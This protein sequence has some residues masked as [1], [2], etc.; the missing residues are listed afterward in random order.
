[1]LVGQENVMDGIRTSELRNIPSVTK[2]LN[3]LPKAE[4]ES[5]YVELKITVN[6]HIC[7]IKQ[8]SWR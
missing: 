2:F 8:V 6:C 7:I 3:E 4:T 5:P 1:M